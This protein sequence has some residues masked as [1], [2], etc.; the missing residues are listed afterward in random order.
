MVA[1]AERPPVETLS[2]ESA[3]AELEK[4]V[5]ALEEGN[6]ALE[7]SIALYE[8]GE[9]LKARC[10]TLLKS[11]EDKVEKIRLSRDGEPVGTEP[12]DPR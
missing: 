1:E 6:V 12:L 3:M 4:I 8:R 5:T 11:A 10:D 2:F 7:R 9:A